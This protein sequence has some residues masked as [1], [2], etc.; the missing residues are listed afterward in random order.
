MSSELHS[1]Y[2]F[3][4][5][6]RVEKH[7]AN[8]DTTGR[9]AEVLSAV[10]QACLTNIRQ[11]SSARFPGVK[12]LATSF[13]ALDIAKRFQSRVPA[14]D[15]YQSPS[16][17]HSR[18]ILP[19]YCIPPVGDPLFSQDMAYLAMLNILA[20]VN[21][22]QIDQARIT[23]YGSPNGRG[24][25]TTKGWKNSVNADGLK[26][27]GE[28]YASDLFSGEL[29]QTGSKKRAVLHGNSMGAVLAL[30]TAIEGANQYGY[31]GNMQVLMDNPIGRD[32]LSKPQI[33]QL[34][35]GEIVTTALN[36]VSQTGRLN[37]Q[38]DKAFYP[39]FD[40]MLRQRGI[41]GQSGL[42]KLGMVPA[43]IHALV[44][45]S[46]ELVIPKN[47]IAIARQ[48]ILDP[49]TFSVDTFWRAFSH[50]NIP[51]LPKR[52]PLVD[53]HQPIRTYA[54]NSSHYPDRF[55]PENVAQWEK[56]LGLA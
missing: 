42:F 40:K 17:N 23:I 25:V 32:K 22:R 50:I 15:T 12:Y 6:A 10:D 31:T 28:L 2:Y 45:G 1:S 5:L 38:G 4:V 51:F 24:G 20:S 8:P 54:I 44:A 9:V 16:R 36:M 14:A 33:K 21:T 34:V 18:I 37:G 52:L 29:L 11:V 48:G 41:Q 3:S 13:D 43:D 47:V 49:L 56:A 30:L 39:G 46:G 27:Y 35:M 26:A 19:A 7:A 53:L 55:D